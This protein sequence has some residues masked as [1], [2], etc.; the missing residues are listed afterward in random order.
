M[1]RNGGDIHQKRGWMD[2]ANNQERRSLIILR[3]NFVNCRKSWA[4]SAD[5]DTRNE[6]CI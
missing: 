2:C 3:Y 6:L 1:H 5:C 4:E